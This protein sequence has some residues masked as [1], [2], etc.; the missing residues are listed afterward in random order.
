MKVREI[1]GGEETSNQTPPVSIIRGLLPCENTT[2][3][4]SVRKERRQR[5]QRPVS[6]EQ[7]TLNPCE[8][9]FHQYPSLPVNTIEWE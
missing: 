7:N 8:N 9:E 4:S 3:R 2:I 5:N 1:D 6:E